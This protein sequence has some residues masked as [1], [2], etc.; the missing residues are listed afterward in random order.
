MITLLF[1]DDHIIVANYEYDIDYMLKKLL[2]EYQKWGLKINKTKFL[3]IE[4]NTED[5]V[6]KGNKEMWRI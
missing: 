2:N 5:L 1:V 4:N 6:L 3:V